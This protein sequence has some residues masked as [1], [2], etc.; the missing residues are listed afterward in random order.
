MFGRA[1]LRFAFATCC[2]VLPAAAHGQI[3]VGGMGGVGGR[4][5]RGGVGGGMGGARPSGGQSAR[6]REAPIVNT[7]DLILRHFHDLALSD[8]QVTRI[9]VVKA[10]QDSLVTPIRARLDS[11]APSR[12]RDDGGEIVDGEQGDRLLARRDALKAYRE[13]LK[14]SRGEAFAVLAK[15]QRKQAERLESDV[16]RELQ[17]NGGGRGRFP[18]PFGDRDD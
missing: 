2:V 9:S 15:K 4:V 10:R 8:P 14:Q 17:Q 11:L 1:L 18:D 16:K 3:G 12:A 6:G 7:V 5:G 13:V